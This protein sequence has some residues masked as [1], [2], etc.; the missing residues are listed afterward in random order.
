M[1]V[2]ISV[3]RAVVAVIFVTLGAMPVSAQDG[4]QWKTRAEFGASVFFGNTSQV[5]ALMSGT[6]ELKSDAFETESRVS[7]T[8]GEASDVDGKSSVNKR[9]WEVGS[10]L[11]LSP[12]KPVNAYVAGKLESAF[13]KRIDLRWSLGGGGRVQFFTSPEGGAEFAMGLLAERTIPRE[14][15]GQEAVTVAKWSNTFR[16]TREMSGGR[17]SFAFQTAY[18]PELENLDAFTFGLR[19]SLS[20]QFNEG[21]ALQVSVKD[22]YDSQAKSRGART[23]NDGQLFFSVV[24]TF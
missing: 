9:S 15:A 3:A 16:F 17:V 1:T 2:P 5:A 12:K 6:T 24:T 8:Y 19:S 11:V 23:N 13:E 22:A 7:Y 21:L 14:E 4:G 18:Q 20:F 10:N